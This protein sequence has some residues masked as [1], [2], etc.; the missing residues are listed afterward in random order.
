MATPRDAR[1]AARTA[2]RDAQLALPAPP[3]EAAASGSKRPKP[4]SPAKKSPRKP[5]S[6]GGSGSGSD[7]DEVRRLRQQVQE[8]Q[9][10]R[11]ALVAQLKAIDRERH[12]T[13]LAADT[14][15]VML[16]LQY[17]ERVRQEQRV[18]EQRAEVTQRE[19]VIDQLNARLEEVQARLKEVLLL[20]QKLE[21]HEREQPSDFVRRARSPVVPEH[22][23]RLIR[24]VDAHGSVYGA[25]DELISMYAAMQRPGDA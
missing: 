22:L 18:E 7:D 20:Q 14:L 13:L 19:Q 21:Q 4:S 25:V 5:S 9:R 6:P 17:E 23:Q 16:Q 8:L 2:L 11:R 3:P 10:E 24:H 1:A 12:D 15:E